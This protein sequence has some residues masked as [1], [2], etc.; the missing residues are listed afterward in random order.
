MAMNFKFTDQSALAYNQQMSCAD[1]P[2]SLS[3]NYAWLGIYGTGKAVNVRE[4][5]ARFYAGAPAL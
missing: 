2:T 3:Q 1:A 5:I 4:S